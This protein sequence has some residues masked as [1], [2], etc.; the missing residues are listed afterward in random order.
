MVSL[1]LF[2]PSPLPPF[3]IYSLAALPLSAS[4]SCSFRHSH[5]PTCPLPVSRFHF[6]DSPFLVTL[7]LA[8]ATP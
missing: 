4:F 2:L 3:K 6:A 1:C 5:S 8:T 7:F